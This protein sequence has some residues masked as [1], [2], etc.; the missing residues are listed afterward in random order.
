MHFDSIPRKAVLI[1][2]S[3]HG[4]LAD[5][6]LA[7]SADNL[8]WLQRWY[9][10]HCNG[11]W[12]HQYRISVETV[13]NPGW[14]LTVDLAGTELQWRE[15]TELRAKR[16]DQDWVHCRIVEQPDAPTFDAHGGTLNLAEIIEIFRG[17]FKSKKRMRRRD[18]SLAY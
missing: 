12:E 17:W 11:D 15:F 7:M 2:P 3:T 6:L 4:R 8:D 13:D 9:R 16:T 5:K 1:H 14:H 18:L 10:A